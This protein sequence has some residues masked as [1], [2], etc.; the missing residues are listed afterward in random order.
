MTSCTSSKKAAVRCPDLSG[1]RYQRTMT[2]ERKNYQKVFAFN[3]KP[4]GRRVEVVRMKGVPSE[5]QVVSVGQNKSTGF[6]ENDIL[7]S[8]NVD[9]PGKEQ[10]V[11]SLTASAGM[12]Y[13]PSVS[14]NLSETGIT[15]I[16]RVTLNSTKHETTQVACDTVILKH[17]SRIIGII[18]EVNQE[19]IRY[20]DC[21]N[22]SGPVL[23]ILKSDIGEIKYSNGATNSYITSSKPSAS[24]TTVQPSQ[25][26]YSSGSQIEALGIVSFVASVAGLI[27]AGIPLGALAVI[28]GGI[29][30]AKFSRDPGR[31]KG[32]GLAI[33]GIIL[34]IVD[35]VGVLI[36]LSGA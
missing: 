8:E 30:L 33:A 2:A 11:E 24:S 4:G 10:I 28:F 26:S 13:V 18:I 36:I 17:G 25:N 21:N 12:V 23:S 20:R 1:N 19:G 15:G 5:T 35:I 9:L 34:G 32:K 6:I 3:N 16:H 14:T 29:S 22:P 31:F 27:I 7:A